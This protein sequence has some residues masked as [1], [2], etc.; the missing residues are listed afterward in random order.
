MT[1]ATPGMQ[2]VPFTCLTAVLSRRIWRSLYDSQECRRRRDS[3][4]AVRHRALFS[5]TRDKDRRGHPEAAHRTLTRKL[6]PCLWGDATP[7]AHR[8][9]YALIRTAG[10]VL[11]EASAPLRKVVRSSSGAPY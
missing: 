7:A 8:I 3:C 11:R 9:H 1:R 2:I 6:L 5:R 10:L 4:A